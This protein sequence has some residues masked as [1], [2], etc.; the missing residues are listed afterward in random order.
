VLALVV[1]VVGTIATLGLDQLWLHNWAKSGNA[2]PINQR[3][4]I[5][6]PPGKSLVYYE[7]AESVP[8]ANVTLYL[9]DSEGDRVYVKSPAKDVSFRMLLGGW[10]GRALWQ[11]DLPRAGVFTFACYNHNFASDRDIPLDDRIVFLKHPDSVED[12]GIV[13]SLIQVTGATITMTLVI[14][15]YLLHG[16]AIYKREAMERRNLEVASD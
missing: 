4:R 8:S 13:R 6:L 9:L 11:L 14:V 2:Y 5:E 1:I 7:S 15:L 10:S 3:L 16:I 12:V